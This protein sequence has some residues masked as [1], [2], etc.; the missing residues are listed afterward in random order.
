MPASAINEDSFLAFLISK[1]RASGSTQ[2][3]QAALKPQLFTYENREM[4]GGPREAGITGL[5]GAKI[6]DSVVG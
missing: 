2:A 3:R 6:M 4:E 1:C 5:V